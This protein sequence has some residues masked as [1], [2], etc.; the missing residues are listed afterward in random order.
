LRTLTER[1]Q[2]PADRIAHRARDR[3][4]VAGLAQVSG[5]LELRTTSA[6]ATVADI[7]R[8]AGWITMALAKYRKS[9]SRKRYGECVREHR[10]ET[11][12]TDLSRADAAVDR[13]HDLRC[14]HERKALR[15]IEAM[16]GDVQGA[17]LSPRLVALEGVEA[18]LFAGD[19]TC[20]LRSAMLDAPT[21]GSDDDHG[22]VRT[23]DCDD[24]IVLAAPLDARELGEGTVAVG[25]GRAHG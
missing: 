3:Y 22:R 7:E 12:D 4:A 17:V 13:D 5:E 16:A 8:M 20:E 14:L 21:M 24:V 1:G 11:A 9:G 6:H 10:I 25:A 15:L 19:A 18:I 23:G 2:V